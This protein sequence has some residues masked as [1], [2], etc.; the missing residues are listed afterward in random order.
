MPRPCACDQLSVRA[1]GMVEEG[2]K[3][4]AILELGRVFEY[5]IPSS[6][7]V[8]VTLREAKFQCEEAETVTFDGFI[9]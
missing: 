1:D 4:V 9:R 2:F 3:D 6:H 8:S 7:V 5:R